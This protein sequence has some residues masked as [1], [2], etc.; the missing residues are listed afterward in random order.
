MAIQKCMGFSPKNA[1]LQQPEKTRGSD[2]E[3]GTSHTPTHIFLIMT[4]I[5]DGG[6]RQPSTVPTGSLRRVGHWL[7]PA[8]RD[9]NRSLLELR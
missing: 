3:R 2:I 7:A 8:F 9:K 1:N 6:F 5:G 4:E